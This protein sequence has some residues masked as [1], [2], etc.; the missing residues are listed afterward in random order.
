VA[1]VGGV[2]ADQEIGFVVTPGEIADRIAAVDR[3]VQALDRDVHKATAPRLNAA[4]RAEWSAFLRRWA[5][6]RDS[7]ASWSARLFATRVIPRV[8]QYQASYNWWA[9]DFQARTNTPPTV[10]P[11]AEVTDMAD[12]LVPVEAWWIAGAAAL[13]YVVIKQALNKYG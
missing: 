11:A 9:R 13:A 1:L 12:S 5:V 8:E 4:W 10:P 2:M 3:S 6:E 7:Y